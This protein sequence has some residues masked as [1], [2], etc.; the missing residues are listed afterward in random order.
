MN[1]CYRHG[2]VVKKVYVLTKKI[3]IN[4]CYKSWLAVVAGGG[5]AVYESP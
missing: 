1:Y 4:K 5:G 2:F 3:P